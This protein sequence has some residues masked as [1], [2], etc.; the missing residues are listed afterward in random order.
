MWLEVR[1]W[2]TR[3]FD[4]WEEGFWYKRERE[5]KRR[6]YLLES[7]LGKAL[8]VSYVSSIIKMLSATEKK[9]GSART[10]GLNVTLRLDWWAELAMVLIY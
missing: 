3:S 5:R 9:E 1:D 10:P 6:E 4:V 8:E 2:R 7:I